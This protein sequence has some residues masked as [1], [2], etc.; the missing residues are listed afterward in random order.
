MIRI[1][2]PEG[3]SKYAIS[4]YKSLGK[5]EYGWPN[6]DDLLT[7]VLVVKLGTFIGENVLNKFPNLNYI[8]THTTGLTHIELQAINQKGI[9]VFRNKLIKYYIKNFFFIF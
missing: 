1:T 2:E 6:G 9:K 4:I 7:E 3:Y 8:V 5:V